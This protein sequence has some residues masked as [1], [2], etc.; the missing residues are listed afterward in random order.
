MLLADM[1]AEVI[2]IERPEGGDDARSWGPPFLNGES[3]W[4]ASVN[5]SKKSVA[6][7]YSDPAGLDLLYRLV[8][9][10]DVVF[11]NLPP[12][13]AR[14]LKVGVRRGL[15]GDHGRHRRRRR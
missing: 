2:K 9:H 1:G 10:A 7:D 8:R 6:L 4:F 5:R 13:V 12:R 11:A 3:L 15:F 14:K